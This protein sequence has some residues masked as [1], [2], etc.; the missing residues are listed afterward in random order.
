MAENSSTCSF[1]LGKRVKIFVM[2][3]ELLA[4]KLSASSRTKKR[5]FVKSKVPVSIRS[6]IRPGVAVTISVPC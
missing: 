1:A 2:M 5:I 3:S 6:I 4:I